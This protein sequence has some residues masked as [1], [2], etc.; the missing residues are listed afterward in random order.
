MKNVRR[1]L[2]PGLLFLL[3]VAF[4]VFGLQLLQAQ[5]LSQGKAGKGPKPPPT[6]PAALE[7]KDN[8]I[9]TWDFGN[10]L[11]V[12]HPKYSG[13]GEF[14]GFV[15]QWHKD[16]CDYKT[17]AFGDANNNESKDLITTGIAREGKGA[18]LD[19]V[20]L[21]EI[22]VCT[23]EG[24]IRIFKV[25]EDG[26]ITFL[27]DTEWLGSNFYSDHTLIW[28]VEA[29]DLDGE[30]YLEILCNTWDYEGSPLPHLLVYGFNPDPTVNNYIL[31]H[32][33][34]V[35]GVDENTHF[36]FDVGNLD[37][38][39]PDEVALGTFCNS[40][41]DKFEV[42]QWQWDSSLGSFTF[43]VVYSIYYD[44]STRTVTIADADGDPGLEVVISGSVYPESKKDKNLH[45]LEVFDWGVINGV[46]G[47]KS[48]WNFIR[49]YSTV[50]GHGVG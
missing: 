38:V 49:T 3:V 24:F 1:A 42:W 45:Y 11:R 48:L 43:N 15:E 37:G 2:F 41:D 30:G 13:A 29:A 40:P 39:G 44:V 27:Y 25:K 16:G 4:L 32:W 6:P 17:M 46:T 18:N 28:E 7:I 31:S 14:E 34:P 36:E 33:Q 50:R 26:S 19:G 23:L 47:F 22:I 35:E 10:T 20:G 21:P 12:W 5:V 9:A 8:N